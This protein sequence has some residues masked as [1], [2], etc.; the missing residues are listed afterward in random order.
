M[1]RGGMGKM[2]TGE[3]EE[4]WEK[5]EAWQEIVRRKEVQSADGKSKNREI[6]LT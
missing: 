2:K 3:E 4:Q 6:I 5:K 1:D